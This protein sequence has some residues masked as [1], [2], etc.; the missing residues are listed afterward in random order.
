MSKSVLIIYT[1]GTVGMIDSGY[2]VLLPFDIDNL[3]KKIPELSRFD[4]KIDSIS[5]EKPLDSSNVGPREWQ[6]LAQIISD[7]FEK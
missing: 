6:K 1:G 3:L 4:F 5:F 2:G 7:N